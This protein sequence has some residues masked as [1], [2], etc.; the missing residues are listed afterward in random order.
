ML[1]QDKFVHL[2][3]HSQYSLLD[4]AIRIKDLINTLPKK[5][6]HSV[7]VTDHGSMFGVIQF[8]Q[9][10]IQ[11][12]IKPIIGSEFYVT[13][14][15]IDKNADT[16]INEE[17]YHIVL[18]AENSQGY[19][20]L[21]KLSSIAFIDG[22]YYKPRIDKELLRKYS[23][24]IIALTACLKGEINRHITKGDL[25]SAENAANEY[26]DIFGEK[27][28]FIEL[29]RHGIPE[30][31]T[32][33]KHLIDIARKLNIPLVATNDCHYLDKDD[34]E[35]HDALLCIQMGTV[36]TDETRM[37]MHT[38]E[39]YVKTP[40]EMMELFSDVPD[41][42]S[43]TVEIAKRC[44]VLIETGKLNFPNYEPPEGETL[45]SYFEKI[46][47]EGL[48]Y[49]MPQIQRNNPGLS[50]EKIREKYGKRLEEETDVIKKTG[51]S[52]YFLIVWDFI[53]YSREVD[54]PV[55]PG[56]GSGA[57]SLVAYAMR[58]TDIDPLHY[59]LLF[60]RFLNPER[61]S[62]P[63]F[64]IDFCWR[65]RPKVID[66]VRE[67]Y[68]RES[69]AQ[70]ITFGT[71][72][73]K[74]AIKDVARVM[75]FSFD[76]SN[77]ISKMVPDELNISIEQALEKSPDLK[78]LYKKDIRV[79]KLID[80]A[81]KLEGLIRHASTHAAGVV[82]SP[83]PI[84]Q[85]VPLYKGANEEVTTQ[86]AMS[87]I[88]TIGLL[89]M[90]FLGLRTL[91]VI[92]DAVKLIHNDTGN[93]FIIDDIPLDDE[94]TFKLFQ[95]GDTTG[96]FQFESSGMRDILKKVKPTVL[97][98]LIALNALYRPG[99]L[100]SG[101]IDDYINRK[102]GKVKITYLHPMMEEYLK[103]TYGVIV[104][105]E[106]VM[107]IASA[108]GGFT[109]GESD[110]LRRAMGKK[111]VDVMEAQEKKFT[112]GA[113]D[114]EVKPAVAQKVFELMSH[115]A[116]Y[117][118][119]KSHS[120]AYA[121]L[122]YQTA[123]LKTHYPVYFMAALLSS[124]KENTDKVAKNIKECR[125][126]GVE[127][128][129][130]DIND[131]FNDF[132][133]KEGKILFG[134]SAIKGVG[135]KAVEE[136]IEA[137]KKDGNFISLIDFCSRVNMRTV[138]KRVI[139]QLIKSGAMD[140]FRDP[141]AKLFFA[142]EQAITIGQKK[143]E[144]EATGQINM[145]DEEQDDAALLNSLLPPD[146]KVWNEK[147]V[148][149][150]EKESLGFYIT[151]HPLSPFEKDLSILCTTNLMDL[152]NKST[153]DEVRVGGLLTSISRRFDKKNREMATAILEDLYSSASLILFSS[154]YEEV[155]D[156]LQYEH[157]ILVKGKLDLEGNEPKV[158]VQDINFLSKV[159]MSE[160]STVLIKLSLPGMDEDIIN[161]LDKIF[162]KHQGKAKVILQL[163]RPQDMNAKMELNHFIS[164]KPNEAFIGEVE[165]LLGEGAVELLY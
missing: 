70:I 118:F 147:E 127:V 5:R 130:P 157:P 64:D 49:R 18:L 78:A 140:I 133:V 97:N 67:K 85:F 112:E 99:P 46:V 149:D 121:L 37:K 145:F 165:E 17:R 137:R 7:A 154:V 106:Q 39:F 12:N 51:F 105:Q 103:E 136:I 119:N 139:E 160:T 120:T 135:S 42:C 9:Y 155:K 150:Y 158:L 161:K 95:R 116:G 52:A 152:G 115:F 30:Q 153:G 110:L 22:F 40:E 24:G 92:S 87:D 151:G 58:I 100:G 56:R 114:K 57:G 86:F 141:R 72:G 26:R 163:V 84:T 20:N 53:R 107:Q 61:V 109:L 124:E 4:G 44:N 63:D 81:S 48:E 79:R 82:I 113:K 13:S 164:V 10:A 122:A 111:K 33:N 21:I 144:D 96:V 23:K 134:L 129:R 146:Y 90:D 27:N 142:L 117:G 29:Q 16:N 77:K 123:Y 45:D 75:S 31:D 19:K 88:E 47:K 162:E 35:A 102:H 68:G 138:N 148:L 25:E 38:Q 55:G 128:T 83:G 98:D 32:N 54:I 74:A 36:L 73:A 69:V 80:I 43:N 59:G 132:T 66:Y 41:A 159:K 15:T 131:S 62:P 76:E 60:Q 50:D 1:S 104:Y 108:M 125:D 89:K 93:D 143:Q 34:A 156:K 14:N 2:H 11:N 8:Y 28:F 94:E 6:M 71:L 65:E 91:T 3:L 101:M 126:M